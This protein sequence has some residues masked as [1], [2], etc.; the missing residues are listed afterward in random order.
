[1]S[2]SLND[3]QY[4]YASKTPH[5]GCTTIGAS[6][7]SGKKCYA[8]KS[9]NNVCLTR[10]PKSDPL[11]RSSGSTP[12][13]GSDGGGGGV[14]EGIGNAVKGA[15]DAFCESIGKHLPIVSYSCG[16]QSNK[17]PEAVSVKRDPNA[18]KGASSILGDVLGGGIDA[19]GGYLLPILA[20]GGILILVVILKR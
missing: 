1:L 10:P 15:N 2:L 4:A 9:G 6:C 13:K 19:F 20:I 7:G 5:T 8:S 11:P 3:L 14:L 12:A 16:Y 17:G 18:P